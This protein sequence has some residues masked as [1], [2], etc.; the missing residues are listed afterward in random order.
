MSSG[1]GKQKEIVLPPFIAN[2]VLIKHRERKPIKISVLGKNELYGDLAILQSGENHYHSLKCDALAENNFVLVIP[3][4]V[5]LAK[6]AA[7]K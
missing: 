2:N 4:D 5:F 7:N 6:V 3:R 1:Q